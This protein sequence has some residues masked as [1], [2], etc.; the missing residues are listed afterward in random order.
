MV[1]Q[2]TMA[3][4]LRAPIEGYAEAI[5]VPPILAEHFE[6]NHSL[7]NMMTSDQFFGHEKENPHNHIH[8]SEGALAFWTRGGETLMV[9]S[10]SFGSVKVSSARSSSSE[11]MNGGGIGMEDPSRTR[12]LQ[13]IQATPPPAS[14]KSIEKICATCGGAH[15]YYQCLAADANTFPEFQDN[16]Q[17]YVSATT[18]NYNQGNSGHRPPSVANQI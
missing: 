17:G 6:L 15:P 4:L 14:V 1:D 5:V 8:L 2:R 12:P 18:V 10:A 11:L 16:I 3:E 13:V 9:Y 7:I